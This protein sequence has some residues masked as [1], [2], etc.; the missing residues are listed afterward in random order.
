MVEIVVDAMKSPSLRVRSVGAWAAGYVGLDSEA[1]L[2]SLKKLLRDGSEVPRSS[3]AT[4]LRGYGNR[5]REILESVLVDGTIG[6][7]LNALSGL[8][9][10]PEGL[11][12]ERNREAQRA[13]IPEIL[14]YTFPDP[15]W[16]ISLLENGGF[17]REPGADGSIPG[18]ELVMEGGAKG[19][20]VVDSSRSRSG[21][22]SL[23][24]VR[25]NAE[26]NLYLRSTTPVVVP[27]KKTFVLRGYFKADAAPLNDVLL[28]RFERENGQVVP[29]DP[30]RGHTHQSQSLLRNSGEDH[31]DKRLGEYTA[32]RENEKVY[33]RIYLNG[34]P[35]EVWLDD[36]TFPSS[37]YGYSYSGPVRP[38]S[39]ATRRDLIRNEATATV[40]RTAVVAKQDSG[41]LLLKDGDAMAPVLYY[42]ML[43]DFADADGMANYAGVPLILSAVHITDQANERYPVNFPVWAATDSYDFTTPMEN[44]AMVAEAAPDAGI[45]LNFNVVWPSDWVELHPDD[46]WLNAEGKRGYGTGGHFRGF[47]DEPPPDHRWWPSPFSEKALEDAAKVIRAFLS[48]VKESPYA[49]RIVGC[50]ISGGHDGQFH[51][52]SWPD[53]SPAAVQAFRQW[54]RQQYGDD[55]GLRKAWNRPDVSLD[56][57]GIPDLS[58]K[59]NHTESLSFYD[60]SR[61]QDVVDYRRFSSA[62]GMVVKEYFA[63]VFKEE[64]G[65]DTIAMTWHL[66]GG[67]G[68]GAH[69][70]FLQSDVLDMLIPQPSYELR[71][72]G[73]Y[74]GVSA[75]LKSYNLHGKFVIKELDLRTWLRS[76]GP[77]MLNQRLGAAM[78]PEWWRN[79]NRKEIG[80]M[81]AAGHGYWYFDIG[82][83]HFRDLDM[84]DEIKATREI[85]NELVELDAAN[86]KPDVA[87]VVS[88]DSQYWGYPS[89]RS[90]AGWLTLQ[91]YAFLSLKASGVPY[92]EYFLEDM[93]DYGMLEDYKVIVFQDAWRLSDEQ[94]AYIEEKLKKDGRTLVW[95]YASGFL[96]DSGPSVKALSKLVGMRV[97]TK[98]AFAR[99]NAYWSDEE[100]VLSEGMQGLQGMGEA[101][102]AMYTIADGPNR[103]YDVQRFY[104]NDPRATVLARYT[105]GTGAIAVRRFPDWTS[106]YVAPPG[107]LEG[108]LLNNI[109]REAGAYVLTE[110]GQAIE[111]NRNFISVHG[112]RNGEHRF[113][114]PYA[115]TVTDLETG[116]VISE[117]ADEF[118][119]PIEAQKQYW[120]LLKPHNNNQK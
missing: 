74:G 109:A 65:R 48:E 13:L 87:V 55:E 57:V 20:C 63:R 17:E 51:T 91:N 56:T 26:G 41:A 5:G 1:V 85:A 114:L 95:V 58:V 54:L 27:A 24:L 34:N 108:Q 86:F 64:M 77:E 3:A 89:R 110:P 39:A 75:P 40:E 106:V 105:D 67:R 38:V 31:W 32:E 115:A 44:L 116:E 99:T 104:I 81:I 47:A 43:T 92:D 61:H 78:T 30:Y 46:A 113:Q 101:Y 45:V 107:G 60:P 37:P 98:P 14:A 84:L 120:F 23:L 93:Q 100:D 97:E 12:D 119:L 90:R 62:R 36:L 59:P 76:G 83:T 117:G 18:W 103:L 52:G 7:R 16:N 70:V 94:R 66:G 53:Y 50:F 22:N 19:Y 15:D 96:S 68:D 80:Q 88:E 29:G 49:D 9:G 72:P 25:E 8:R 6:E 33:V 79:V 35:A 42:V 4:A 10:T 111:M 82:N 69:A 21:E 11:R 28:F 2:A 71:I 102:R 118:S 112:M 73:Y